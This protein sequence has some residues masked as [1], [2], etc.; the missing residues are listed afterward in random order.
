VLYLLIFS[1]SV[2]EFCVFVRSSLVCLTNQ[3]MDDNVLG[4]N[5]NFCENPCKPRQKKKLSK[6]TKKITHV[7]DMMI[8]NLLKYLVQ[9]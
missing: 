1:C 9:I 4:G 6:F 2:L 7:D 5:C 3:Y 8:H